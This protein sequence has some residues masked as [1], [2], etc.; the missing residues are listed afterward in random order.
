MFYIYTPAGRSFSGSLETM[1][2]TEKPALVSSSRRSDIDPLEQP[3]IAAIEPTASETYEVS[4]KAI[5]EYQQLLKTN[6][7]RE[8]IK[9]AYQVMA[10]QVQ[11]LDANATISTARKAFQEYSFQVMPVINARQEV[12][13]Y[14]S[15]KRLYEYLLA[16]A[17]E[18]DIQK[19]TISEVFIN[20]DTKVVT[21]AAVTDIRRIA[22]VLVEYNLDALPIVAD[23]G[24]LIGI[25]SRTD[26]L[27]SATTEPPLSLWC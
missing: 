5:A 15:R 17:T 26:I 2:R 23:S 7:D 10:T 4:S 24:Q 1:R 18:L 11:S 19:K 16:G 25:V 9:H 8:P 3:A 13:G 14:L 27:K 20:D 22:A 12:A 6:E 21:A